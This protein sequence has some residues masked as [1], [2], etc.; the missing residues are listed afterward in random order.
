MTCQPKNSVPAGVVGE[1]AGVLVLSRAQ[2]T[3]NG[4]SAAHNTSGAPPVVE[5]FLS[6]PSCQKP[7]HRPS[8][9]KNGPRPAAVAAV[10]EAPS[11]PRMGVASSWSILRT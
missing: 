7:I 11:V 6:W 10:E 5:I 4:F 2:L 3:P 9:E 8:G 1:G